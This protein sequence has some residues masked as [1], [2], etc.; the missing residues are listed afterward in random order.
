ML[1]PSISINQLGLQYDNN[2]ILDDISLE[3]KAGECHVIMGP[4]GGGKT[5]LLRSVLGLTPF[6]GQINIQWPEKPSIGYVPQKATFES[7]LP[8]TVMDFVLLNQTRIPLFWR[9]KS[10]QLDLALAQLDRVGM[11][12]R[13][14]R[15]MGQLSGGEQQRVLFAQAL[16]DNPSLLVL[17]EPTTGMDEQGVR[18]LESL[19]RECVSEGRTILAVHHDVT[20]V[21]R[22]EANVHVVN[23][24]LVD[25]GPHEEVL[26]PSK[27]ESLFQHY[28]SG[29]A[30]TKSKEVA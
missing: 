30:M 19:I 12:T 2:V 17:D 29:S 14:D 7:S 27:I 25:S 24:F 20:A 3:L 26:H 13:S 8:L 22:L 9:R 16:L 10:K 15:R 6:S 1:G 18:Y 4:N 11:A 21:R 5:S 28:S 23:R